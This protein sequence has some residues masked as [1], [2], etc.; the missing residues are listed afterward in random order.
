MNNTRD[1]GNRLAPFFKAH[2]FTRKSNMFYKIQNNIAFCAGLERPGGLYFL[3]YI[4]PLYIPT[5]VRHITYGGRLQDFEPFPVPHFDFYIN[6]P[7]QLEVF[8]ERTMECCEKYVFPLYDSISTP[9]GLIDFLN[10]GFQ[11]VRTFWTNLDIIHY[12]EVK[13]YTNFVL[14]HY[15]DMVADAAHMCFEIDDY[16]CLSKER[17]NKWKESIIK[18]ADFRFAPAEE[19]EEFIKNTIEHSIIACRFKK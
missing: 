13:L 15:D 6:E 1:V 8:V 12:Y 18:F 2:G 10:K 5:S 11:Y 19:K 4:I 17:K 16:I 14:A 3:C 9:E 7:S